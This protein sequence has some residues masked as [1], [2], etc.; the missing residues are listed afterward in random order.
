MSRL[1][2]ECPSPISQLK[3]NLEWSSVRHS[4]QRSNGKLHC[5]RRCIRSAFRPPKKRAPYHRKKRSPSAIIKHF[6]TFQSNNRWHSTARQFAASPSPGIHNEAQKSSHYHHADHHPS[7]ASAASH[8]RR[9]FAITIHIT[10]I[11]Q[12]ISFHRV[13]LHHRPLNS[14]Y[15]AFH[16]VSSSCIRFHPTSPRLITTIIS[17][18]RNPKAF[19]YIWYV[20]PSPCTIYS[21]LYID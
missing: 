10:I 12:I 11:K 2:S 7:A 21:L 13:S 8:I 16:S 15:L 3:T 17:E 1:P 5:Y 18:Y 9:S 19:L 6:S 4:P 14:P 20:K